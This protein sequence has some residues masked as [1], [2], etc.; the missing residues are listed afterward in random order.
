MA[1]LKV[2][3]NRLSEGLRWEGWKVWLAQQAEAG[4]ELEL[5]IPSCPR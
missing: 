4:I 5:T 2:L 1:I 3:I